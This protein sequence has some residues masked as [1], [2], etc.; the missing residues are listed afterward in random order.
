MIILFIDWYI[1]FWSSLFERTDAKSFLESVIVT[2]WLLF[3][4]YHVK[5]TYDTSP[6]LLN[7]WFY[8]CPVR[9][10]CWYRRTSCGCL[11]RVVLFAM[12]DTVEFALQFQVESP[13]TKGH[14]AVHDRFLHERVLAQVTH[15]IFFLN[16]LGF[17]P[18]FD[19]RW[20]LT[21]ESAWILLF[22]RV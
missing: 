7:E 21:L 10:R 6:Y 13:T 18:C 3:I 11:T 5:N 20:H 19:P 12:Q 9:V 2:R 4:G 8:I 1:Y 15:R 16:V 17:L 22:F 14:S